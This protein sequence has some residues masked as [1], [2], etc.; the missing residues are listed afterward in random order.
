MILF[1]ISKIVQTFF[2][3]PEDS[4]MQIITSY[5]LRYKN[6]DIRHRRSSN[7]DTQS[8]AGCSLMPQSYN[9]IA[10]GDRI[11]LHFPL[12]NLALTYRGAT[13]AYLRH[14]VVGGISQPLH[15]CVGAGSLWTG[16]PPRG[17]PSGGAKPPH[18]GSAKQST[19]SPI[20]E[21]SLRTPALRAEHHTAHHRAKPPQ[22]RRR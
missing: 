22:R 17:F 4:I 3:N 20:T 2:K 9:P 12:F 6:T 16:T 19:T 10:G 14:A 5:R 15:N 7:D 18:T 13:G 21:R 8:R 11:S 1:I